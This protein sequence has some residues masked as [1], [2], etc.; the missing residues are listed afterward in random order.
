MSTEEIITASPKRKT[1]FQSWWDKSLAY[2]QFSSGELAR[3][4][5]QDIQDNPHLE[6][7]PRRSRLT[8]E[9]QADVIVTKEPGGFVVRMNEDRIPQVRVRAP[10]ASNGGVHDKNKQAYAKFQRQ[11]QF[12][13]EAIQRRQ[14]TVYAVACEIVRLQQGFFERG[15]PGLIPLTHRQVAQGMPLCQSTVTRAV[16][17]KTIQTPYGI[18]DLNY[19]FSPGYQTASGQTISATS[20]KQIIAEMIAA[21]DSTRPLS[22]HRIVARLIERGLPVARRTVN[23]YRLELELP[24]SNLRR[25]RAN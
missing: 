21:E 2:L 12:I 1:R 9:V 25:K 17:N 11:A 19:F 7:L 15:V 22:D 13:C 14:Q 3:R 23:K 5:R 18:V 6:E 4:V 10:P 20:V 24:T 8:K 16:L